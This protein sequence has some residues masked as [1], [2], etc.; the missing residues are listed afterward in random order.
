MV[1]SHPEINSTKQTN[2]ILK[3]LEAGAFSLI[4]DAG[5]TVNIASLSLEELR[6]MTVQ[7][8][9]AISGLVVLL[10]FARR[11]SQ[12]SGTGW[13]KALN[14]GSAWQPSVATIL[15]GLKSH[16]V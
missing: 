14:T 5:N 8:N 3:E 15:E 4:D 2:E 9:T 16:L 11:A 12:R 13:Q 1:N 10:E 6:K 7:K